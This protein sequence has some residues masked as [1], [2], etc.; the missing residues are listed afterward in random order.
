[1]RPVWQ[2]RLRAVLS[3]ATPR[4]D[5]RSGLLALHHFKE[6]LVIIDHIQ[7]IL[8]ISPDFELIRDRLMAGD[9]ASLGLPQSARPLITA[10]LFCARPRPMLVCVAGEETADRYAHSLA[11][12]LGRERVMRLPLR[13]D[14][15]WQE[16]GGP[17]LAQVA[18]RC[19]ALHALSCG[20]NVIVVCSMAALMRCL[21]PKDAAPF[22]PLELAAGTSI[23]FEALAPR[24]LDMGYQRLEELD[25]P[26][27][28]RLQGD[29]L[30]IFPASSPYPV[31]A[32]FFGDELDELRRILPA[33]GQSIGDIDHMTLY[34]CREFRVSKSGL[35]RLRRTFF[36]KLQEDDELAHQVEM[37]EQGIPFAGMDRF[38]PQLFAQTSWAADYLHPNT[39]LVLAEPRSLLDD[40]L[41]AYD[42]LQVRSSTA[43]IPLD[44]LYLHPAKLEFG[45]QQRLTF[46]S[47]IRSGASVDADLQ[48]KRPDLTGTQER[49]MGGLR[50]LVASNYTVLLSVPSYQVRRSVELE[51]SDA[52]LPFQEVLEGRPDAT[53]PDGDPAAL[54]PSDRR[55]LEPGIVNVVDI[56]VPAGMII[57]SAHLAIVSLADASSRQAAAARRS[58]RKVDPTSISFPYKPGDYVVHSMHGIALFKELLRLEMAGVERD[59]LLLEYAAGDKLYVPVEQLEKVTRYV[60]PQGA[61]PRLTRLNSSDWNRTVGKA[62]RAAK[63][64]AFDLVDLYARRSTVTGFKY[65]PDTSWQKE[66]EATFPHQCTP[67]QLAAIDDIK[68]DMESDKPMDRL[69]CG[70]VGFGKTEVVLRAAFKAVQDNRQVMVLCPTTILA[71]QHFTTFSERFEPFGVHVEVLSR[72]RSK[73]QQREA[74]EGFAAGTVDVMVGTHRLLS[75][76]VNP[77][78]L[79]LV[80]IDEE[81]RFGVQHKEQLKNIREQVDVITLSATP[82]PRT[83]QMALSGVRDMSLI[84]TP[85]PERTPISVYVGEWDEDVVSAAIRTELERHGQVYYVSNRVRTIEEALARVEAAAPEARCAVAH[86]QMSERELERVMESFSARE[87]DVLVATTIIESGLDN[88]HTNTLIIEDS[89]RLG[90]A[91]LYQLKGRVG[92]SHS[93]AYA[94]FLFPGQGVLTENATDRLTAISELQELGSGTKIALRDLEIRGAGNMLGAEQ[95]GNISA[96]GFDLYA[97]MLQDAIAG[98]RGEDRIAHQD[99]KVDLPGQYFLPEDYI[100]ATDERMLWY[101][102]LAAAVYPEQVQELA[103]QLQSHYGMLPQ[104]AVNLVDRCCIKALAAPW[105]INTIAKLGSKVVMQPVELPRDAY[106][107]AVRHGCVYITKTKKLTR[108]IA[109]GEEPLSTAL[110]MLE[111]LPRLEEDAQELD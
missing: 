99:I 6:L 44:G 104:P 35:T 46:M 88:P 13:S 42:D 87:I 77:K 55:F 21:P 57:P 51:L 110:G 31:R 17:D 11:A 2:Q 53:A 56:D 27:T 76:D 8:G 81:Q 33:T 73:K 98:V 59:Y 63:K 92:R 85:P 7:R 49:F 78:N 100:P 30:D 22:T 37:L 32:S 83:L 108:A 89:Q 15:P 61:A 103:D 19:Q 64:M 91:Q 105:G 48:V 14:Y 1:M 50:S 23:E 9:D 67:D 47:I 39:L 79:G 18:Q 5:P 65:S 41:R 25:G 107:A 26:G 106:V 3:C 45:S 34:P 58:H 86:G 29:N 96:V 95:S 94:Y 90:L 72:F 71:Q 36:R 54:I 24:L 75:R 4:P 40:A 69:I 101:R 80:I 16:S 62:G 93:Q 12:Y 28:F 20:V 82:I 70:D 102:R 43:R 109:F 10:A 74:L 97:Q 84:E 111:V 60:G 68:A 38:L 52:V 66:M